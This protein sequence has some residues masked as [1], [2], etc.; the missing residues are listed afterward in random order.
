MEHLRISMNTKQRQGTIILGVVVIAVIAVGIVIAA[1]GQFNT[2][3]INLSAIPT[4]RGADGAFILG[5][6]NAPITII[7]FADYGC[8]HCQTYHPEITRFIK[9]FVETGRAA[10][11]YRSFPTAGG[12]LTVFTSQIA[13]CIDNE[14]PGAF[15][16][17]Y[18]RF[19]DL[20][21]T[22]RYNQDAARTVAN[23]LGMNYTALLSCQSNA[24]QVNIDTQFGQTYGVSGTPAVMMRIGNGAPQWITHNGVTYNRG[25]VPYDVL[26][27]VVSSFNS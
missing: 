10:F 21:G 8:P 2:A 5:D 20:A 19:Y 15:W 18:K 3:A 12:A 16:E 24:Q 22:A 26:A 6:P 14:R 13:E 7:E 4:S 25:P 1:S 27:A 11:E 9:D 17:A 23:D